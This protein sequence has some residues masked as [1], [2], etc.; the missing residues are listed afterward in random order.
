[1][2]PLVAV[3]DSRAEAARPPARGSKWL[4]AAVCTIAAWGAVGQTVAHVPVIEDHLIE[5]TYVG[6][7]MLTFAIVGIH[8][9]VRLLTTPSAGVWVATGLVGTAEIASYML[10]RTVG[11]P[12]LQD[13]IGHWSDPLGNVA[14]ICETAMV[15]AAVVQMPRL[16]RA[17][18][19]QNPCEVEVAHGSAR[20]NERNR[21]QGEPAAC[22]VTDVA[23]GL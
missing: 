17:R 20:F 14:I 16:R 2:I 1:V 12:Q 5:A 11:L 4:D 23:K 15:C 8:L 18:R 13:D 21:I 10:S 3:G 22:R 7:G 6:V 19:P 9:A